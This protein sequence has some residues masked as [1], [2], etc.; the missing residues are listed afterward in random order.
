M[1][2]FIDCNPSF[3]IYTQMSLVSSDRLIIPMMA[4]FSSI[5]GIKG[6]M[7]LLYDEYPTAALKKYA[8]NIMTFTKQIERF[9]DLKLPLIDTFVFNNYTCGSNGIAKAYNSLKSELVKFCID[10]YDK[11]PQYFVRKK[12]SRNQK[13]EDLYIA[14]VRDFHSVGRV[15]SSLGIPIIEL[16]K[17]STYEMPDGEKV[18]IQKNGYNNSVDALNNLVDIISANN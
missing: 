5:E 14:D 15:S 11:F 12:I 9:K 1:V 18:P 6:I 4:D 16:D 13:W 7:T 2:V 3:S 8:E 17:Q 10:Q